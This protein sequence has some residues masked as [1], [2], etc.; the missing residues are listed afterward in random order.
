MSSHPTHPD[1][2]LLDGHF[3]AND[4]HPAFTWMRAHA[5]VYWDDAGQV[6]G[7]TRYDDLMAISRD[8]QTFSNSA[9]NRPDSPAMPFMISMD[10]PMHKRRRGLVNKG[11][12]LRRVAQRE[13]RVREICADVI[14]KAKQR[15]TFDFVMDLAAWIPLIV[16]GDML[17]VEPEA[18]A[19]L[20]RWSDDM[21]VGSGTTDEALLMRANLAFV[22][23]SEYQNRVIADRRRRPPQDDLVSILVHAEIDGE[24]LTDDEILWES[25]LILIGGDET[26]R[27]VLTGGM[28]EL[29]RQR[30]IWSQLRATPSLLPSAIEEMLR[31]VTPI[32]NM[33]RILLRD[34]EVRGQSMKA[35][36]QLLL[37]YPSANRDEA[38]F[39][40]PFRFDLERSPNDHVAFGYGAHFCLG[41]SLARLELK[42]FFEEMM[43]R[44]P[45]LELVDDAPPPRRA[46]NFISGIEEMRVRLK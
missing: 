41:A 14:E 3:Y 46:S 39:A 16:I 34:A 44:M 22:E 27:H 7:I 17:G 20:L 8:P 12:T 37:L 21:V 13:A 25:L 18:H 45:E 6:W 35:G 36:Q 24:K 2:R 38:V 43:A 15:G 23:Y 5:P 1:V 33:S 31:W 32:Q 29:I 19:N 26:T 42:V 28:Y 11:F 40:D 9:G 30:D 4:P 10:D